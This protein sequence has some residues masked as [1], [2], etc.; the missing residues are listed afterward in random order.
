MIIEHTELVVPIITSL[1]TAIVNA[2]FMRKNTEST[3]FEKLKAGKFDEVI[4]I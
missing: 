4:L 3:E 1:S 2:L